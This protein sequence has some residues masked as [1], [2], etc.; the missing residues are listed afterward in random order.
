MLFD[1]GLGLRDIRPVARAL[2]DRP[3]T[4]VPSHFHYDHVGNQITFEQV[5]VVDL[6]YLRVRAPDGRLRLVFAEHLGAAER[7]ASP[8][9]EVDEWLAPGSE[10]SLGDRRL[11]VLH[12]PGHTEESISLLEVESGDL[13]TGDFIYPGPLFAFLPNSGMGDYL[14][15]AATVLAAVPPGARLF[16]AHRLAPPAAPELAVGDVEDLQATLRAIRAGELKGQGLYPVVYR[17]NS[18]VEL[19]AE[20]RLLQ[21]WS[22]RHPFIDP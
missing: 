12:T 22:P 5:A 1:A 17:V 14:Q 10:I 6:P 19:Y 20:P 15:G 3:I 7:I 2:T 4:F 16:G 11:R 13:F 9:L 21:R 8:T 18:R